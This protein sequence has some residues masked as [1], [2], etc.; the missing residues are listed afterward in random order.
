MSEAEKTIDNKYIRISIKDGIMYGEYKKNV[1]IDLNT[2]KS[3]VE[4]R[5]VLCEGKDYP[6]LGKIDSNLTLTKD[7]RDYLGKEGTANMS[8]LGIVVDSM[9]SKVIGNWY[10]TLSR[11]S[12]PTKLFTSEE[13]A[14]KWLKE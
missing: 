1:T 5:I 2:A 12:I 8:K 13:D 7:A 3:I 10:L 14:I 11:P 4:E 9:V 6:S